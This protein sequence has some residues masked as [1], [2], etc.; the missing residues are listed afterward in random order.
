MVTI[1][2]PYFVYV[3]LRVFSQTVR[4][5]GFVT[6]SRKSLGKHHQQYSNK[7][8]PVSFSPH[9][10]LSVLWFPDQESNL[11]PADRPRTKSNLIPADSSRTLVTRYSTVYDV[12]PTPSPASS[13]FTVSQD[14]A[15]FYSLWTFWLSSSL[16]ASEDLGITNTAY[17]SRSS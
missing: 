1:L 12:C 8:A 14:V 11:I 4:K 16:V 6:K 15:W 5:L 9:H 2:G 3:N 13:S 17:R 7:C 10:P